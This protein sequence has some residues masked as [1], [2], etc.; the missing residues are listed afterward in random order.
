MEGVRGE[1][2]EAVGGTHSCSFVLGVVKEEIIRVDKDI[3]YYGNV[4]AEEAY[5]YIRIRA[6]YS[7]RRQS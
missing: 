6:A 5:A 1:C 3:C 2:G 4:P 7:M